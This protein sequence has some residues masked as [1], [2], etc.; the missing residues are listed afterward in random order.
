MANLPCLMSA[1]MG[2]VGGFCGGFAPK[3]PASN[4]S[5]NRVTAPIVSDAANRSCGWPEGR[6]AVAPV[7]DLAAVDREHFRGNS[8]SH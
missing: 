1:P 8:I 6:D 7:H 4:R 3:T 5:A 2:Q